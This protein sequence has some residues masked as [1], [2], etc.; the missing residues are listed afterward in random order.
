M[1]GPS[2]ILKDL[3]EVLEDLGKNFEDP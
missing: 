1:Q 2:R 3:G